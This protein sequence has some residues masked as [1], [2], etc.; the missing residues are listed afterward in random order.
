MPVTVYSVHVRRRGFVTLQWLGHSC[1]SVHLCTHHSQHHRDKWVRITW[2]C[3][4]VK[5]HWHECCVTLQ[6]GCNSIM[7]WALNTNTGGF[8]KN[9]FS[10]EDLLA[11]GLASHLP[12]CSSRQRKFNERFLFSYRA[13]L[14]GDWKQSLNGTFSVERKI[15][16]LLFAWTFCPARYSPRPISQVLIGSPLS[17]MLLALWL[18]I[19]LACWF[20]I[21]GVK[22][23]ERIW[24]SFLLQTSLLTLK[25][26]R[27][28]GKKKYTHAHK[29][30]DTDMF[31]QR[32]L[33]SH[34][35]HGRF[36]NFKSVPHLHFILS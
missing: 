22:T 3:L 26:T 10:L 16:C 14:A 29:T 31:A 32:L 23:D 7:K 20:G 5:C 30:T 15:F 13:T 1:R 17:W 18:G 33:S 36:I 9:V 35:F 6:Q 11:A 19:E 28:G 2:V 25:E 12:L 8:D 21:E 27:A 24:R 4:H 34:F